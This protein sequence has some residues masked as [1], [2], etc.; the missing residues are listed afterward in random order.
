MSSFREGLEPQKRFE[1][2]ENP[3]E[4][5]IAPLEP[6]NFEELTELS[7]GERLER[8]KE[9]AKFAKNHEMCRRVEPCLEEDW[10]DWVVGVGENKL[11]YP[12]EF[13]FYAYK[14]E[15]I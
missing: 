8:I 4:K 5:D 3:D 14:P 15:E 6:I 12:E 11:S 1:I 9:L 7:N 13:L 10:E 2:V